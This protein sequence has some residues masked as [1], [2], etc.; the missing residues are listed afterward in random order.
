M[1]KLS[2]YNYY[3]PINESENLIFNS[4]NNSLFC[5]DEKDEW[6]LLLSL[7]NKNFSVDKLD[8]LK[9]KTKELLL[10]KKI[11]IESDF[12]EKSFVYDCLEQRNKN[13]L[14]D[15]SF[16]I[17]I[18]PTISCNMGCKY[19]FEGEYKGDIRNNIM[20]DE[21]IDDITKF[22]EKEIQSP[23]TEN[24]IDNINIMWFG[25]EPLL[26]LNVIEKLSK[27]VIE[28]C[29][30]FNIEYNAEM[31]SNGTLLNSK[32]W[33][34]L[35][36][37]KV[38]NIQV[39]I[40]GSRNTHNSRRPLLSNN[41]YNFD[42]IL[43]NLSQK[44]EEIHIKIRIGA[45]KEVVKFI[46]ELLLELEKRKIWPHRAKEFKLVLGYKY[47]L[48]GITQEAMDEYFTNKEFYEQF[49]LFR[50]RQRNYFNEWAVKNG[51]PITNLRFEYPEASIC[52]TARHPYGIT[53]DHNGYIYRCWMRVN[54]SEHKLQ[55]I[56]EDYDHKNEDQL[57]WSNFKKYSSSKCKDCKL[58]P[59][60]DVDCPRDH[61]DDNIF[62]SEWKYLLE[63]RLKNQYLNF[64]QYSQ[65]KYSQLEITI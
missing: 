17:T 34:I 51:H 14:K 38:R 12:D 40:D 62:C 43:D 29:D 6:D 8:V 37:Y 32:T 35:K 53:I 21:T 42:L 50:E 58:L 39:P 24:K 13:L 59:V 18:L 9:L 61:F 33:E 16:K 4:I 5:V 23:K 46:D 64:N 25:G 11:I 27:K 20:T 55:H 3:I 1:Y 15:N 22:I 47:H 52:A 26:G 31:I 63:Q 56:S 10:S 30:K 2:Y 19:C 57:I 41:P 49:D 65:S 44:P 54:Q 28:I 36:K 7:K 48:E 45:D 60:C